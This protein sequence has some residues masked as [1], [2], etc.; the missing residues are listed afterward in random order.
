MQ[1]SMVDT[2]VHFLLTYRK[3]GKH[4]WLYILKIKFCNYWLSQFPKIASK[5]FK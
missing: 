3:D 4:Y 5:L 1:P 2:L